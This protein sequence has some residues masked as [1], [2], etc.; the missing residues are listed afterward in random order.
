[1]F[2]EPGIC[3]V[4]N[5]TR[6]YLGLVPFWRT[7][8]RLI[9]L[10]FLWL[11]FGDQPVAGQG[12]HNQHNLLLKSSSRQALREL[13][14]TCRLWTQQ[15]LRATTVEIARQYGISI[16]VDRRLDPGL[17]LQLPQNPASSSL[18]LE[19]NRLAESIGAD[20]GLIE[21]VYVIAPS[22]Q[23]ARMQKAAVVL[24]GQLSSSGKAASQV[25]KPLEWPN[26]CHSQEIL[27]LIQRSW[28]VEIQGPIP[29]DLYYAGRIPACSLAT[30]LALFL[31]GFELQ[32]TLEEPGAP[33]AGGSAARSEDQ[34]TSSGLTQKVGPENEPKSNMLRLKLRPLS[35]STQW[36]DSYPRRVAPELLSELRGRYPGS[37][38]QELPAGRVEVLG[39][40]NLHLEILSLGIVA[41]RSRAAGSG[42]SHHRYTF[43]IEAKLPVQAVLENL[44]KSLEFELVWSAECT[45]ADRNRLIQLSVE[46]VTREQLLEQVCEQAALSLDDRQKT[47]IIHPK[48]AIP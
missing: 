31:G 36:K 41:G 46:N 4:E 16:W 9:V 26:I 11:T 45:T 35:S 40:T 14:Q 23:L 32:A 38:I 2:S 1:M 34:A 20:S 10:G 28:Q 44:S 47:I 17:I 21:N 3:E 12:N 13:Q 30:Q 25:A 22:G 43:N 24:H 6:T 37:A 15:S 33:T 48:K 18:A 27:E 8:L 39:D 29:H 7:P 42:E 19:L 5:R